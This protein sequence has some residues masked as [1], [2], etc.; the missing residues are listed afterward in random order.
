LRMASDTPASACRPPK[1]LSM[2]R[3]SSSGVIA[4]VLARWPA[5]GWRMPGRH[6]RCPGCSR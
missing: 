2:A 1:R 3:A 4:R 5:A 6:G